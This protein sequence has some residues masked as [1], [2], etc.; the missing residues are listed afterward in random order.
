MCL[1][2]SASA[3]TFVQQATL[4]TGASLEEAY[5]G[6]VGD[7]GESVA[8]SSDGNVALVGAANSAWIFTRSGSTWTK[9]ATLTSSGEGGGEQFG[10]SVALSARGNTALVGAP[11]DNSGLGAVWVFT[12]RGS[13]WAQE[14]KLTGSGESG[15]GRFGTSVALSSDGKTALIGGPDDESAG[16][17]QERI[18]ASWVF[19]RSGTAWTQQGD[20]LIG[21][22][23][24]GG[25]G[26]G[27]GV[28]LSSNGNIALI[29]GARDNAGLGA[30][31]VFARS[32]TT[33]AQ[34]GAKLTGGGEVGA[35]RFG[36]GVA[37][38]ANGKSALIGGPADSRT[39][40]AGVGAAW[41][42]ARSGPGWAQVGEK[43]TGSAPPEDN[44]DTDGFGYSVALSAHGDTAVIG[45]PAA[46]DADGAAS[47]F[48]RS[49]TDWTQVGEANHCEGSVH[50][51]ECGRSVALSS[52]GDTAL[53]G[54]P[55]YRHYFGRVYVFV[56]TQPRK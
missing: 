47:F 22:G 3:T 50:P 23:E 24:D 27:S 43:L 5:E 33:W 39:A 56:N 48:S 36:Q 54:S 38:S 19:T 45:D 14:A 20:K 17:Y 10:R 44:A 53:I 52:D 21:A 28:A 35:G 8:L 49:G 30:A 29:G 37:L 2:A 15:D 34:Q 13:N 9:Q 7:L 16:P 6:V 40:N 4:E 11:G 55:E 18:G 31:W 32:G 42:F 12:R 41:A 25:G 46:Y 51:S 26:F 1:T